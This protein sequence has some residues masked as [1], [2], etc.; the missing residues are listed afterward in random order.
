V[1]GIPDTLA[2]LAVPIGELVPYGRNARRGDVAAIAASLEHHGQYRPVVANR[3]T[4]EVLAGNHTLAAARQL[5]WSHIAASWVD[6]D[7]DQAARIVLVDNKSNDAAGYDEALLAEILSDL[8]DLAGT[9]FSDDELADLLASV[10]EVP[11]A[12]TDADDVP[13]APKEPRSK[14]GDVWLLGPHR[15]VVGDSTSTDD[16]SRA[17]AGRSVDLL[18]TDPPYGVAVVGGTKDK[19]TIQNDDLGFDELEQFLRDAFTAAWSVMRPGAVFYIAAPAGDMELAFRLALR[20]SNLP[21]RQ[22][23]VWVKDQFTLGRQDHQ[24]Q[25]ES[26]LY[27]WRPDGEP[28]SPPHFEVEHDT[29]LYGWKEGAGHDWN[30]GRKQSTVWHVPR[31]K[32]NAEHPTMKPVEL[33]TRAIE[34]STSPGHLVLDLFGGSGSTLIAAHATRRVAALVELDPRY[35]DVICRRYQEHVG[36]KPVLEG[37]GEPHD[38]TADV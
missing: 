25:H 23:L 13:V 38:F 6:V 37:T 29:G 26:L 18:W 16:V 3:R 10:S 9:G 31:P 28:Q 4:G 2:H 1:T 17:V 7:A 34:N 27:G 14:P 24:W 33:I 22:A 15:L 32:R 19:L 21:L 8:P 5:G 11:A 30:G 35:A 12:L 36:T 20:S